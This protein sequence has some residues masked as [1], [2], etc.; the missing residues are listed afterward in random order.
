MERCIKENLKNIAPTLL[1]SAAA[2]GFLGQL[3]G[4]QQA[5][6]SDLTQATPI[7]TK[8]SQNLPYAFFCRPAELVAP[9]TTPP[10]TA[11]AAAPPATKPCLVSL[12]GFMCM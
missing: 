1:Q 6:I 5:G 12:G 3:L 11:T 8:P 7:A 9:K 4:W 10:A 2:S